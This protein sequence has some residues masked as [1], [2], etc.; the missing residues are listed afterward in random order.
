MLH[1]SIEPDYESWRQAARSLLENAV[2]PGDVLWNDGERGEL[3]LPGL[4][5]VNA[6]DASAE[7]AAAAA[8]RGAEAEFR[9]PGAFVGLARYVACHRDAGRWGL[10]YRVLWRLVHGE[11]RLLDLCV[12][13]DVHRLAAMEKS[14]RRDRHKMTAFVRFRRVDG[15]APDAH[16]PR[17]AGHDVVGEA[18]V[19]GEHYVAWHRPDHPILR[20]ATPFFVRRFACMRWSILTPD[21]SVVWDGVEARFGPGVPASE[22]PQGDVLE[23]LWRTYYANIFNPARVNV[24]AMKRELPVRHWKTLPES[25]LIPE[26]LRDAPRRTEEM[27]A[28]QRRSA[29]TPAAATGT[30]TANG[31]AGGDPGCP[32]AA[33]AAPFVPA[34]RELPVLARAA[35]KCQGCKLYCDATQV[36]FGE[37]PPDARVMFVGEQPGD[38]EDRAGKPFVG[39]AGKLLD[40]AMRE[41]GVSRDVVYVTNAV[42]HFKFE[43]RGT[44][45]IHAKPSAREVGACRPW[46]EAEIETVKPEMIVCLGATAAQ[47]LMGAGFRIT[48]HRG[49]VLKTAWAPWLLATSHPSAILRVP[50]RAMRE[51]SYAQLVADLKLVARKLKDA[52]GR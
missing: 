11:R 31:P 49:E 18:G 46:L 21:A 36:V 38:Q 3:M 25:Q 32:T 44:R 23:D 47:S 12:D 9:V 48:Q 17:G 37:G 5:P 8:V 39:P 15:A 24:R 4:A 45:R 29:A 30:A 51:Q 52:K 28:K 42:K 27:V 7:A 6:A 33:S 19:G 40:D 14:V 16:G 2:E 1:V 26:L 34:A 10:L 13:E 35:A 20:L 22:A 50:D 43:P 41:A